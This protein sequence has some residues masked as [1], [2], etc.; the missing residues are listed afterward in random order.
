[1][2]PIMR[3]NSS[4]KHLACLRPLETRLAVRAQATGAL[5][6]IR[7]P[8]ACHRRACSH[9]AGGGG[10]HTPYSRGACKSFLSQIGL[11]QRASRVVSVNYSLQMSPTRRE[12]GGC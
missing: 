1:M 2:K 3:R 8:S 9:C 6:V 11:F 4:E 7:S 12:I 5:P 10:R